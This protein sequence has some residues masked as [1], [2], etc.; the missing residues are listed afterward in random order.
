VKGIDKTGRVFEYVRYNFSN[1]TDAKIRAGIFI[2]PQIR[3][4]MQD[5]E[6]DEDL[7][8]IERYAWMSFK[9]ICNDLLGNC[10][11]ANYQDVVKDLLTSYKAMGCNMSEN[12]LSGATLW[13]FPR[14][15]QRSQEKDFTKTLWLRKIGTKAIE[16]Q[17][18]WKTI[19]GK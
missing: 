11:A 8:E 14:R 18:C 5:I 7:N 9:R 1:V 10:K 3:E 2:G 13:F 4:L 6:F 15:T 16:P 12:P 19:A 17:V